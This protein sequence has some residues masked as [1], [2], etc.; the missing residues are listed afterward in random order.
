MEIPF[1]ILEASMDRLESMSTLLA[2]VES[3]S[4]SAASRKLGMPLAT[5]SRKVSEL[6]AHLRTR[7][8]NR[9]SRRLSLTDAGRSYVEA[10]KQILEDIGEA[11][12][13]AT[14]EYIVPRGDLVITAPIVFGRLHVL[15][16]AIEFLKAYP[17]IDIRVALADHMVNLQEHD[18][19]LA[20]RI[21]ELPDSSLVA[22][23]VGSIRQ[24]VC[25]SP[26]YF[27]ERGTPKS[28]RDL[29]NH[30]CITFDGLASPVSWKFVE[31]KST[32]SVSIHSRLIVNTAEAAIDTAIAAVG[33]TRVL[34]YQIANALQVGALAIALRKYEPA[35]WPVSLVY[36][37]QGLLPLKLRAFLDFAAP[38]LKLRLSQSTE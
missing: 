33:V 3:G 7:L 8:V 2:A 37:G 18:V 38:R 9:T 32:V 5:V 14:G 12:R 26:V 20:V 36:A 25:G 27:A 13:A 10:C 21:G 31:G 35:P 15:P 28:P 6:E 16:V 11:E 19:D 24:V 17:D 29:T 30:H 23:R 22:T 4:L 34:S 1:R